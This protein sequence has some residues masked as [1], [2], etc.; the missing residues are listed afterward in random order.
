MANTTTTNPAI[1]S[2]YLAIQA[3]QSEGLASLATITGDTTIPPPSLETD[4]VAFY[5]LKTA[6]IAMTSDGDDSTAAAYGMF[7]AFDGSFIWTA[8]SGASPLT[9]T[10][11]TIGNGW[12]TDAGCPE[13]I[14]V[15]FAA[16]AGVDFAISIGGHQ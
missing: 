6:V 1:T 8:L 15:E 5:G 9:V 4:G 11:G 16:G 13:R 7:R 10:D 12:N 14:A 2:R 3:A